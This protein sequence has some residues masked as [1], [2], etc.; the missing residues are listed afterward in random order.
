[1]S[2]YFAVKKYLDDKEILGDDI[3]FVL[4]FESRR[5]TLLLFTLSSY[6]EKTTQAVQEVCDFLLTHHITTFSPSRIRVLLPFKRTG[7]W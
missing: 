2:A 6:G 1:M 4:S 3:L 5:L 7:D